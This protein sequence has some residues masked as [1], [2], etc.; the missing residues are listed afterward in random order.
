MRAEVRKSGNAPR[1]H[2]ELYPPG[3]Q[4]RE[5]LR[6]LVPAIKRQFRRDD[7]EVDT[8]AAKHRQYAAGGIESVLVLRIVDLQAWSASAANGS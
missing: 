4:E 2:G 6:K 1:P 7:A 8:H 5:D 3:R